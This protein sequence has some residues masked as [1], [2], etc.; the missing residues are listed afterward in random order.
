MSEQYGAKLCFKIGDARSLLPSLSAEL[1]ASTCYA[2]PEDPCA[3]MR[4]MQMDTAAALTAAGVEV[5]HWG[6]P[7]RPSAPWEEAAGGGGGG[8]G[9]DGGLHGGGRHGG[10]VRVA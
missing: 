8:G 1:G 9:G 5:R 4:R 10:G 2:P 7:L 3:T 6:H